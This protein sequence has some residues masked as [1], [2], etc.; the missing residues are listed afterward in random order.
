MMKQF[1]Y[2]ININKEKINYEKKRLQK[3]TKH[4]K[5]SFSNFKLAKFT[6]N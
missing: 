1:I 5:K 2:S 4:N 3:Y 6:Q